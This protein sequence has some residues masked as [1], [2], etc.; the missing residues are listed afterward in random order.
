M[1]SAG[2]DTHD[3]YGVE[4]R[5]RGKVGIGK[6]LGAPGHAASASVE[7]GSNPDKQRHY[8][9]GSPKTAGGV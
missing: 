5:L 2:V 6:R 4:Q 9:C 8:A 1:G 7:H 3:V